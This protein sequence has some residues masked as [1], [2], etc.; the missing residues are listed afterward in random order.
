M[1][2][3]FQVWDGLVGELRCVHTATSTSVTSLCQIAKRL[4]FFLYFSFYFFT[5]RKIAIPLFSACY[6]KDLIFVAAGLWRRELMAR[7]SFS[8][9]FLVHLQHLLPAQLTT[10]CYVCIYVSCALADA[11][12]I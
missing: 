12:A 2:C 1:N 5:I 4:A 11:N 8:N 3:V 6:K 7:W 10:M 9:C